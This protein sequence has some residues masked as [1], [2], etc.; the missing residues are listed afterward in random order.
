MRIFNVVFITIFMA[1]LTLPLV[2]VDLASDRVSVQEN[3]RLAQRPMLVDIK[4][5]PEHFIRGFDAWFKDS[6]GFREQLLSLYNVMEKNRWLNSILYTDGQYTYLVGEQ[7]HHYF[8]DVD[9]CLIP[10]FQGKSFISDDRLSNLAVRLEKV[11]TYL[12]KQSIPLIVMFNTDK[13]SLYPEYYPKGIKQGAEPIQLDIITEYLREHTTVDVF[14]IREALL[15]EK[16]NFMLYYII[17]TMSFDGGFAHYNQIGA[18]FAYRELMRHINIYFPYMIP[19]EL[20]D[21]DIIYDEKEIPHVSLKQ[22]NLYRKLD[23]SF[24]DDVNVHRPFSW[25]NEAYENTNSD[26]PAILFL[27]DSYASEQYIGK[28][29]A[30]HFGKAILVHYQNM[31]HFEEYI[32]KYKPDIVVF[33]SAE[34]QLNGFADSVAKIPNLP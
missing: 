11:K 4:K 18:F 1:M 32:D 10:K 33:E 21:V 28:Y 8:A 6:T 30:Q 3:R 20:D 7:G 34:R 29:I 24:F 12:D 9:G 25:E 16:D 13:E 14:N 17:D 31:E 19:Y 27:R 22:E 2:F 5:H 15:A 23:P 26:L